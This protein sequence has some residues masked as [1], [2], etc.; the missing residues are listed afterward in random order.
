[1]PEPPTWL[2]YAFVVPAA[3]TVAGWFVVAGQADRREQRKDIREILD[4]LRS[5]GGELI[6]HATGYWL[7]PDSEDDRRL[8]T[9]LKA[10]L[11][12][13]ARLIRE[14]ERAGL[15][16]EQTSLMGDLRRAAT[17]GNFEVK[18]RARTDADVDRPTETIAAYETLDEALRSSFYDQ[19]RQASRWRILRVL[20]FPFVLFGLHDDKPVA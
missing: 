9:E 20:L 4:D 16:F 15:K 3:L 13:I 11:Q 5:R 2:Q 1:M 19:F 10:D 12:A 14:A 17:A 8:A 18:N 7:C 6:D